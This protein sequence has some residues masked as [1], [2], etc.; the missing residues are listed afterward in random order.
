[1]SQPTSDNYAECKALMG[2]HVVAVRQ[3]ISNCVMKPGDVLTVFD[4]GSGM[5]SHYVRFRNAR[6]PGLTFNAAD[7]AFPRFA[8][9]KPAAMPANDRHDPQPFRPTDTAQVQP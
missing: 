6:L 9:P 1:M 8:K 2:E 3:R 7:W 4:Y 5:A